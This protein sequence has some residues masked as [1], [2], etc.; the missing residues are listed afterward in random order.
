ME[1]ILKD[2]SWEAAYAEAFDE[3]GTARRTVKKILITSDLYLPSVNGV[4][5]S[6][7]NLVTELRKQGF[8]VRILTTSYDNQYHFDA[9]TQVYY[10]KSIPCKVYPGVRMPL[11]YFR[12]EYL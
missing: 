7:L 2:Q 4:V 6:V 12:H 3:N 10:M 11:N 8:E 9:E 5:T 1:P